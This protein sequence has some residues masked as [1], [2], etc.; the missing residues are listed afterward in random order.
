MTPCRATASKTRRSWIHATATKQRGP[1][2][3]RRLATVSSATAPASEFG[4]PRRRLQAQNPALLC[5][6][7]GC[8]ERN[9]RRRPPEAG[10]CDMNPRLPPSCLLRTGNARLTRQAGRRVAVPLARTKRRCSDSR[11]GIRQ[12]LISRPRGSSRRNSDLP[13]GAL[14]TLAGKVMLLMRPSAAVKSGGLAQFKC[15]PRPRAVTQTFHTAG[16]ACRVREVLAEV[17]GRHS[18]ALSRTRGRSLSR[19]PAALP[20]RSCRLP[21][22]GDGTTI[23]AR[24][25]ASIQSGSRTR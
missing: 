17:Q 10:A 4:R 2:V 15:F 3:D 18:P 23:R 5:S 1:V 25:L 7:P 20:A 13:A 24:F 14:R 11:L 8:R 22:S 21:S 9:F 19:R 12:T 16:L 6:D